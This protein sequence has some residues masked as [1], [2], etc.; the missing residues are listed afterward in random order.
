MGPITPAMLDTMEIPWEL[1]PTESAA[2][3]RRS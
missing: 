1:F 2:L 3:G